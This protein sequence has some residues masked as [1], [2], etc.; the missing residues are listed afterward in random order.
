MITS[1]LELAAKYQ[2]IRFKMIMGEIK[3]VDITVLDPKPTVEEPKETK[4]K[5]RSK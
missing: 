3:A 5:P 2:E 1:V 4:S